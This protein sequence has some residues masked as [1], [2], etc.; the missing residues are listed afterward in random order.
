[1]ARIVPVAADLL[2]DAPTSFFSVRKHSELLQHRELVPVLPERA[3]P[4][5]TELGDGD[6]VDRDPQAG[7]LDENS[8][9]QGELAG[10]GHADGPLGARVVAADVKRGDGQSMFEKAVSRRSN[11][12]ASSAAEAAESARAHAVPS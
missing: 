11:S 6:T 7:G 3:D 8:T 9:G 5:A 2:R 4:I 1:M 10:V 12:A